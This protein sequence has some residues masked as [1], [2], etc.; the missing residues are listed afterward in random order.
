MFDMERLECI[1][2][3]W[4]AAMAIFVVMLVMSCVILAAYPGFPWVV[5]YYKQ[6]RLTRVNCIIMHGNPTEADWELH[7]RLYDELRY[8]LDMEMHETVQKDFYGKHL[9]WALENPVSPLP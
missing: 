6:Y 3:H 4:L 2:Y 9:E 5:D 8:T 7:S 1:G